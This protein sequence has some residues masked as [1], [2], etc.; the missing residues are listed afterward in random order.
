MTD[1]TL[2]ISKAP[3]I[4]RKLMDDFELDEIQAAG[5][6]GNIGTEC[7]GFHTLH[8]IGQP[9][10]KGGYGWAQWT[11]PRRRD[12]FEFCENNGFFNGGIDGNEWQKDEANYG[13][14]KFELEGTEKRAISA[15]LKTDT[16]ENAVEVFEKIF[17]GAGVP[18]INNRIQ[19]AKIALDAFKNT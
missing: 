10:G 18:N 11:G 13:F 16:L 12:F 8:E 4:M 7:A 17:E 19:W 5:I 3:G 15:L 1:K 9:K 14:L 6:L 2:F